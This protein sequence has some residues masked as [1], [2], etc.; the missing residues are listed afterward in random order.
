MYIYSQAHIYKLEINAQNESTLAPQPE[1][2]YELNPEYL[3]TNGTYLYK[4]ESLKAVVAPIS[5]IAGYNQQMD[6][7]VIINNKLQGSDLPISV[8]IKPYMLDTVETMYTGFTDREADSTLINWNGLKFKRR[9]LQDHVKS[10]QVF[11]VN[12]NS[13]SSLID[14]ELPFSHYSESYFANDPDD[15]YDTYLELVYNADLYKSRLIE[16]QEQFIYNGVNYLSSK[17]DQ[18]NNNSAVFIRQ[19]SE[20]EL[21]SNSL[22]NSMKKWNEDYVNVRYDSDNPYIGHVAPYGNGY[23]YIARTFDQGQHLEAGYMS[24]SDVKQLNNRY[25][26]DTDVVQHYTQPINQPAVNNPY[27]PSSL[28]RSLLYQMKWIYPYYYSEDGLNYIKQLPLVE[29]N[30]EV[31]E[32]EMPYNIAYSIYPRILFNDEEQIII[33]LMLRRPSI[34]EEEQYELNPDDIYIPDTDTPGQLTDPINVLD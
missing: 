14:K 22:L 32:S 30:S 2:T 24:L 16:D 8:T 26:F 3:G 23:Q 4:S 1:L 29:N 10:L 13:L 6:D 34:V 33:V 12:I 19:D 28:F 17:Y 31:N 25:F 11:P 15:I 7:A 20:Y 5:Y 27:T 18:F 9:F 21:R